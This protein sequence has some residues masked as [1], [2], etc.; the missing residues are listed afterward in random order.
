M[1]LFELFFSLEGVGTVFIIIVLLVTS[2]VCLYSEHYIEGYNNK[3][4]L[5]LMFLFLGF[6]RILACR[7][8]FLMFILG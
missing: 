3:K 1:F 2:L 6:M 5:V 4:F 8:D 7:G